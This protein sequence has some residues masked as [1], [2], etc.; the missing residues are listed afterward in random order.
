MS[1][2]ILSVSLPACLSGCLSAGVSRSSVFFPVIGQWRTQ[3]ALS[4]PWLFIG[5]L[6]LFYLDYLLSTCHPSDHLL[7]RLLIFF[8]G[9]HLSLWAT[10]CLPIILCL[11]ELLPV[12]LEYHRPP[13]CLYGQNHFYL[14]CVLS[15]C[16]ASFSYLPF[17]CT[18]FSTCTAFSL[19]WLPANNVDLCLCTDG[20]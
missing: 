13:S 20:W 8:M 2:F 9:Y 1:P 12:Y 4:I 16:T 18:S 15:V 5:R 11:P 19:S 17:M 10:C 3:E 6:P 7:H 14:N